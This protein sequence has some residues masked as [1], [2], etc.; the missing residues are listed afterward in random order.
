MSS[1]VTVHRGWVLEARNQIQSLLHQGCPRG[2][3]WEQ[4][5]SLFNE[6]PGKVKITS[7]IHLC[8]EDTAMY[9]TMVDA[10]NTSVLQQDFN[11]LCLWESN[12]DMEFNPS[13]CQVVP[14]SQ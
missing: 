7:Q 2:L 5:C 3:S 4:S 1:L 10:K 6:L 8:A 14:G 11:K 12:W 13:E 9:L